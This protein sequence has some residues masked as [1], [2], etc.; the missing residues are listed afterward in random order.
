MTRLLVFSASLAAASIAVA[1]VPVYPPRVERLPSHPSAG[2]HVERR[3]P[4]EP[5]AFVAGKLT[6][7]TG[8]TATF[9]P[10]GMPEEE[11]T[12]LLAPDLLVLQGETAMSTAVLQP[13]SN[14]L[15]ALRVLPDGSV[16][17]IGVEMLNQEQARAI[18]RHVQEME[19]ALG[20]AE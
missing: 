14:A 6:A 10:F 20:P 15:A 5:Q 2:D 16:V 18:T 19:R 8:F 3:L 17:A 1:Q 4:A 9:E 12:V 11:L 7:I 13:G